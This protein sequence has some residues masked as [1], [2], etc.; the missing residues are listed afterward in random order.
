MHAKFNKKNEKIRYCSTA[1]CW[2][3]ENSFCSQVPVL[4]PRFLN[5]VYNILHVVLYTYISIKKTAVSK[6]HR[7][8][9]SLGSPLGWSNIIV[10]FTNFENRFRCNFISSV[11][12]KSVD[13]LLVQVLNRQ[14]SFVKNYNDLNFFLCT[15]TPCIVLFKKHSQKRT[16]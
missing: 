2:T 14:S 11:P 3:G 1:S 15:N 12:T 7:F 9:P 6:I 4:F 8:I 5:F 16:F 13:C 10:L